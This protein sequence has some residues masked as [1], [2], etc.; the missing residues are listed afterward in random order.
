MYQ[1][2]ANANLIAIWRYFRKYLLGNWHY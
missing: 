1:E 2:I